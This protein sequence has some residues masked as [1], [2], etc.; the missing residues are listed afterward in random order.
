MEIK[1]D[2]KMDWLELRKRTIFQAIFCWDIPKKKAWKIGQKY[3]VAT[4]NQ[5]VP[6]VVIEITSG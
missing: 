3:M 6:E 5:S 4:S 1:Q 2:P